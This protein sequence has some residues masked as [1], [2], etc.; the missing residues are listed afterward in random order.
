MRQS[1]KCGNV[2]NDDLVWA[3]ESASPASCKTL[4]TFIDS[5]CPNNQPGISKESRNQL[6]DPNSVV[7]PWPTYT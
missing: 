2:R 7:L 4:N 5:I 1:N 3:V 6:S